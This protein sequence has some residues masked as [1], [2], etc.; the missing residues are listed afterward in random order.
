MKQVL[1]YA[2]TGAI[3]VAEVP[4]PGVL[5]GCVLVRTAA[6]I[7]S[8]GTERAAGTFAGK[9][10][11]QKALARPDLVKSVLNKAR[12][13]GIVSAISSA[14]SRL[15]Q[16]NSLG[17]SSA[18]TVVEVGQGVVD[19]RVGERVA[20]A[21]AGHA[22]HA[23]YACV[24]RLLTATVPAKDIRFEEAAFA[25]LGAVALHGLR[26]AEATLGEV[27]AV[28][29]LGLIG[30][31]TV[32]LLKAAGCRVIGLDLLARRAQMALR[33]GADAVATS[34][35]DF[36]ELCLEFSAGHG[37]DSVLITAETPDSGPVNLAAEAV[38]E[39]GIVVAVG[40]V[41]MELERQL[42]YE[43]EIAFRVSRSYGPGRY[44]TSYE[45]KGRDYP[46]GYVRWT[47]NRNMRAFL[48]LL[49]ERKLHVE[50][51]ITHRIGVERAAVAYDL[52][53]DRVPESSL[54]VVIT[55][56]EAV[57]K[58][59]LNVVPSRRRARSTAADRVNVGLL[60]AGGFA[61][62]TLIPAM[63]RISGVELIGA[64]A[65][66]GAHARH[67]A[68][69]FG[70]RYSATDAQAVLN[71]PEVNT[72][73]IATRH[74][75]HGGQVLAGLRAGKNIFC[76]KPLCLTAEALAEIVECYGEMSN[77]PLLMVGFNR[78]FA[79]LVERMK[80]FIAELNE[81]LAMNYRINAGFLPRDHWTNDPEQGGGRILGEACHFVDL[82]SFLAGSPIVEVQ[83]RALANTGRYSEDNVLISLQFANGSQGSIS[84]LANGD[85]ACSKERLEGF[86]GGC[87]AA[88]EDFRSLELTRHGKR[89][90][91]RSRLRQDKGHCTEWEMFAAAIRDGKEAPISF[92]EIIATTL[93]TF[94]AVKSLRTGEPVKVNPEACLSS[95]LQ[96][97]AAP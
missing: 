80:R 14:R 46:I 25:T 84:Y 1:Q 20:C 30:Q 79:P 2:N 43:K 15:D 58:L 11:L 75:L 59:P 40:T 22:A 93:A 33:L 61:T 7:V 24:P 48:Q 89:Q 92:N 19:I 26:T 39:R 73:A 37:A 62:S 70:F 29:G 23:E 82:L 9:N 27:I 83:T 97:C 65:A 18:G 50:S 3:E 63:K 88:M 64:C 67:A 42:Y 94:A 55:Y 8:A 21:G 86:G 41:G 5:P 69:K 66:T 35:D 87:A 52:I 91:F 6:S 53:S 71:D 38:R 36:R 32:Q 49:A 44:D 10:L 13:D 16:P 28:I 4:A 56:S 85:A 12:R 77:P 78:R 95:T 47:E 74:H 76:E 68:D 57:Q 54:G 72:I 60:G 17:Y 34:G 81:P 51:L 31:L 90:V 45:Q 96:V